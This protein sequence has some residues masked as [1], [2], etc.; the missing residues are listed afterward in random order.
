SRLPAASSHTYE[1]Y[2]AYSMTTTIVLL[3]ALVLT[4]SAQETPDKRAFGVVPNYKT[5]EPGTAIEPLSV[6]EKFAIAAKDTFDYPI[7][8]VTA[9]LAGISHLQDANPSFGQGAKGYGHR[10]ITGYGDQA[11]TTILVEGAFPSAFHHDP[12]Y[13]RRATGSTMS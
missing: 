7:F 6:K 2:L 13:F 9:F 4:A 3:S 5:V 12:R 1:G 10:Y 11:I 8:G